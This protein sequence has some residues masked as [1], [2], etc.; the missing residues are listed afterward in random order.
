MKLERSRQPL[1]VV[2]GGTRLSQS[3]KWPLLERVEK[4]MRSPIPCHTPARRL[5]GHP[6]IL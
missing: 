1:Y 4:L 6:L 2:V 3:M 5:H